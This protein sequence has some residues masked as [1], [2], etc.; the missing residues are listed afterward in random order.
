VPA[1]GNTFPPKFSQDILYP[2]ELDLDEI[3]FTT[4]NETGLANIPGDTYMGQYFDV[5]FPGGSPA[6]YGGIPT[7]GFGKHAFTISIDA[8]PGGLDSTM[9]KL[10][11]KS[12]VLFEV[13]DA[14]DS[15]G[16]RRVIFS[17]VTP[18]Y[19]T[20]LS[21]FIAYLWIKLDP[22][23]TYELIQEGAGK[24]TIVGLAQ[25]NDQY[26]SN[27]YNVRATT[28][29]NIDTQYTSTNTDGTTQ[30]QYHPNLSP[31][32]FKQPDRLVSGSGFHCREQILA[33]A[34]GNERSALIITGSNLL[35]YSGKVHNIK[36]EYWLSGSVAN[37]WKPLTYASWNL[38]GTTFEENIDLDY[39][40]G[41]NPK[42]E[43]W[44]HEI[45]ESDIPHSDL[46]NKVKFRFKF[47]DVSN[48]AAVSLLPLSGSSA[49]ETAAFA[50]EYPTGNPDHEDYADSD[51]QWLE[52]S[53][54]GVT[55]T[56]HTLFNSNNPLLI[57]TAAGQFSFGVGAIALPKGH[58]V[59]YDSSGKAVASLNSVYKNLNK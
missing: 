54:S 16:K 4:N 28:S 57:S 12:R 2:A 52:M 11:H 40:R 21:K 55:L 3:D 58:G 35:T 56:G 38:A 22:L 26:W 5:E 25:T 33:T 44:F 13:K 48:L 18:I 9:V 46:M 15:F 59:K 24:I 47:Y 10:R 6:S 7:L 53:G 34:L 17:D 36:T 37:Q 49:N 29:I 45:D 23:R 32:I 20:G 19:N 27:K 14:E 41:I 43:Q 8:S 30:V 31:I 51:S 50:I 39:A 1:Q 42:T